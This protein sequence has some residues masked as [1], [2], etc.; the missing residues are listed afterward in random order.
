MSGYYGWRPHIEG[1]LRLDV[2]T[3]AAVIAD[4]IH[5]GTLT[6]PNNALSFRAK[7]DGDTGTLTL[8]YIADGT[9]VTSSIVL[10]KA[11]YGFTHRWLF[12]CPYTGRRALKL[13]K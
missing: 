1:A 4:G 10:V 12:V 11:K 3:L 7:V 8:A 5:A 6:W 2:G 9:P 13:Y